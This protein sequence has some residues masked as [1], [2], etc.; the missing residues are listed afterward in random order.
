MIF[1]SRATLSPPI[2]ISK[3]CV[4]VSYY[5]YREGGLTA[6]ARDESG[7]YDH[8]AMSTDSSPPAG[9]LVSAFDA[10][11][12]PRVRATALWPRWPFAAIAL[13]I[14]L[15]ASLFVA[16]MIE[17]AQLQEEA[18]SRDTDVASQQL[19]TRVTTLRDNLTG[20]ALEISAGAVNEHRFTA[21]AAELVSARP[22]LFFLEHLDATGTRIWPSGVAG[23]ERQLA[24]PALEW[25][26]RT[27]DL[28]EGV[29]GVVAGARPQDATALILYPVTRDRRFVGAVVGHVSLAQLLRESIPREFGARYRFAIL[30]GD[31]VLAST[32]PSPLDQALVHTTHLAPLPVDIVLSASPYQRP[33]RVLGNAVVWLV[34][35]LGVAVVAALVALARYMRRQSEADRALLAET[36]LRR[37]MEDSLA[38]G[39]RVMDNHGVIRYVNRAFCQMTGYAEA[40]LVGRGPPYPYWPG[41]QHEENQVRLDAVLRGDAPSSSFEV[42]V[43]RRDGSLFDA[44]MYLSPLLDESS[45][46]IGWMTSMAD[47]TVQHRARAELAAAQERFLTV[48]ESL[49]AAVSVAMPAESREAPEQVLYTNRA[50]RELFGA[51]ASG[52]DSL[53]AQLRGREQAEIFDA[54]SRR[55]FDVR[56]RFV[57]WP[58]QD[59][60]GGRDVRL[61]IASDITT[62]KSADELAR[63]QQEKVQF[64]ARLMTMGELATSLAHELNQPLTAI[65][66]YSEGALARVRGGAMSQPELAAALQKTSQQAQRAGRIIQRIREFVK[67]STPH[68][69]VSSLSRIVEDAIGFAELETRK[70]GIVIVSDLAGDLPPVHADPVLIEQVLLNLLKNAIDAMHDA[71]IR[72]IDV[73]ARRTSD[74]MAEVS[75]VDRGTGIAATELAQVFEPFFSTKED[76][77]G[78][79]LKICRSIVEFHH[80]RLSIEPNREPAGGT[81]VRFT[82]PLARSVAGTAAAPIELGANAS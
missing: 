15:V 72:R 36:A 79:G 20:A 48:L 63:Q 64:T 56:A 41:G 67:R 24:A 10:L 40:E 8:T 82:L 53:S 80:G 60:V 74:N 55:W 43:Q 30:S 38:T 4:A 47:V 22:E 13:L 26:E 54:A 73:S 50:Y 35:I 34:G 58:D 77:M 23:T 61:Q 16:L 1:L 78:M 37:A 6:Y 75:V 32:A 5:E 25:F 39:L 46:Q 14:V 42:Q 11:R 27:R 69:R 51:D 31:T 59:Y 62:R 76:G 3:L 81:V 17:E 21:L 33:S 18:L 12:E 70:R 49:D 45:R 29:V 44:R 52:H 57:R 28:G 66:N 9:P 65:A 2:L 68:R 19:R 7:R 71:L